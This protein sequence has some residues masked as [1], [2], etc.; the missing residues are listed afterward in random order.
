M[1]NKIELLRS[2]ALKFQ[3]NGDLKEAVEIYL[4]ILNLDNTNI[5]ALNDLGS[6][7]RRL[8]KYEDSQKH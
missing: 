8:L 1:R 4:Q 2:E 7:Y 5:V 3:N 6:I